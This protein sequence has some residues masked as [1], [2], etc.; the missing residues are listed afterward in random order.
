MDNSAERVLNEQKENDCKIGKLCVGFLRQETKNK[1][2]FSS[3][4]YIR[5][6]MELL[7][8]SQEKENYL[9]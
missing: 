5:G 6:R 7:P 3:R 4:M 1:I 9:K 8:C 2:S